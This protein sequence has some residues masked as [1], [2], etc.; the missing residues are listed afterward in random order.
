MDPVHIPTR[1]V[2][3]DSQMSCW[4]CLM[5]ADV[6]MRWVQ[7][8]ICEFDYMILVIAMETPQLLQLLCFS[9]HS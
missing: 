8:C 3:C 1:L 2:T 6:V 5:E 7:S 4:C 9:K